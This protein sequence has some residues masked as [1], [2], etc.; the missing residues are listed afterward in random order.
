MELRGMFDA[1][2][3]AINNEVRLQFSEGRLCMVATEP[4]L[5]RDWLSPEEDE[6]WRQFS[7]SSEGKK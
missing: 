7:T 2:M 4:V 3:D 5:S 1:E 6:A